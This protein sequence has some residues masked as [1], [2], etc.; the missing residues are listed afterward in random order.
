M[1]NTYSINNLIYYFANIKLGKC[2]H[3]ITCNRV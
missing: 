1:V 2:Y 3:I